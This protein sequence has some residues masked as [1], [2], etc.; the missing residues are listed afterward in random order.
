MLIGGTCQ[1]LA[2]LEPDSDGESNLLA[3]VD[4]SYA[5]GQETSAVAGMT[6]CHLHY[7][8][9]FIRSPGDGAIVGVR[10]VPGLV[11]C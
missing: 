5:G 9:R 10:L 8:P 1:A 4:Q 3:R 6:E 11:D 2:S 7:Q